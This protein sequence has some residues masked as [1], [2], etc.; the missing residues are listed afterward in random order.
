MEVLWRLLLEWAP[1]ITTTTTSTAPSFLSTWELVLAPWVNTLDWPIKGFHWL[2]EQMSK[3]RLNALLQADIRLREIKFQATLPVVD[4]VLPSQDSPH[5]IPGADYKHPSLNWI[6]PGF[7]KPHS[8][9][10]Q[11]RSHLIPNTLFSCLEVLVFLLSMLVVWW[12]LLLYGLSTVNIS[13]NDSI[14]RVTTV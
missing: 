3:L 10:L 1:T 8:F 14:L 11:L 13:C 6:C 9:V 12:I 2:P 7:I 5:I 4:N